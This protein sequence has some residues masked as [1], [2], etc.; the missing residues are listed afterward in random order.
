M[1]MLLFRSSYPVHVALKIGNW[2]GVALIS[3][4]KC[5]QLLFSPLA[6]KTL[7]ANGEGGRSFLGKKQEEEEGEKREVEGR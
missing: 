6:S 3:M 2:K 7:C 5:D 1:R 4:F